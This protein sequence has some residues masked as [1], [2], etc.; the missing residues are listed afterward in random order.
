[1][2][3]ETGHKYNVVFRTCIINAVDHPAGPISVGSSTKFMH[4]H[5][6]GPGLWMAQ[7]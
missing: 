7:A 4:T 2:S 3:E 1:M 5:V 6:P